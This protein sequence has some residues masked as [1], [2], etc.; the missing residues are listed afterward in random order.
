MIYINKC[1]CDDGYGCI[2]TTFRY[3]CLALNIHNSVT[4]TD[5]AH[6]IFPVKSLA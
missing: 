6:V 3:H 4:I 2:C 5:E 1:P